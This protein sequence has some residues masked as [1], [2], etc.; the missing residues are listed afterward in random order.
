VARRKR[1][2][3]VFDYM[4]RK[5]GFRKTLKILTFVMA[6][7]TVENEFGREPSIEEYADWWRSS[8]ATAFRE[9]ALFRECFPNE[10][11]PSRLTALAME[12]VGRADL[13]GFQQVEFA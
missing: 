5:V 3:T 7:A 12:R 11:T 2:P 10:A 4:V 6:W 9:Q 13:I 8:R 1:Q